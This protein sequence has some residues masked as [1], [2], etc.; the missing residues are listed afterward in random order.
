MKCCCSLRGDPKGQMVGLGEPGG[1]SCPGKEGEWG[2]MGRGL[3]LGL[4]MPPPCVR[5]VPGSGSVQRSLNKGSPSSRIA[6]VSAVPALLCTPLVWPHEGLD[7]LCL[8]DPSLWPWVSS[9]VTHEV[10]GT[11]RS[12]LTVAAAWEASKPSP[13]TFTPLAAACSGLVAPALKARQAG[14]GLRDTS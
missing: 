11:K 3:P 7:Q 13:H 2:R 4:R 10:W 9:R 1:L 5:K 6:K 14:W 8:V 12:W